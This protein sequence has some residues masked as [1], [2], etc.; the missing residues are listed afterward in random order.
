[1]A[2]AAP[3]ID[4]AAPDRAPTSWDVL[5]DRLGRVGVGAEASEAAAVEAADLGEEAIPSLVATWGLPDD[6]AAKAVSLLQAWKAGRPVSLVG[7]E[8]AE[9]VQGRT[10]ELLATGMDPDAAAWTALRESESGA[11]AI[12]P[13]LET[14][15]RFGGSR[16]LGR[17][18]GDA[19]WAL[20]FCRTCPSIDVMLGEPRAT[21][22]TVSG[23][24]ASGIDCKMYRFL[25]R[26]GRTY[27]F[28]TCD[29][30]GTATFDTILNGYYTQCGSAGSADDEC[31]VLSR[32]TVTSPAA[33]YVYVQ[34]RDKNQRGGSYTLSYADVTPAGGGA[35][36]TC[37]AFDFGTLTPTTTYQT[38]SSTVPAGGC[39][40]YRFQGLVNH[41]YRFTT[42]EGGG[43]ASFDAALD[44]LR[45]N[46]AAG[47]SNDDTCGLHPQV[48]VR[49]NASGYVYVRVRGGLTGGSYTLA[50]KDASN[51]CLPCPIYNFGP[52]TPT[53]AWTTHAGS[54]AAGQTCKRYGFYLTAGRTYRFSTCQGGGSASFDSTMKLLDGACATLASADDSCGT[55]SELTFTAATTALHYL[56]IG[57]KTTAGPYTLAYTEICRSCGDPEAILPIPNDGYQSYSDSLAPG[58]CAVYGVDLFAGGTYLF[59]FCG[60]PASASFDT[61]LELRPPGCGAGAANDNA[62]ALLSS[63][64]Y[65]ASVTGRH[66]LRVSAVSGSGPFSLAYRANCRGCDDPSSILPSPTPSYQLQQGYLIDGNCARYGVDL[67]SGRRYQFTFCP[68]TGGSA[69]FDTNLELKPPGCGAAV[70][71]NDNAC[72]AQARIDYTATATG[73]HVLRIGTSGGSGDYTLAY[74]ETCGDCAN[75]RA[76]LVPPTSTIYDQRSDTL[77]A[78][79]CV[80]YAAA[81]DAGHIYRFTFCGDAGG[82]SAFD[83]KIEILDSACAVLQTDATSTACPTQAESDFTAPSTGTYHVR[84]TSDSASGEGS[85]TLAYLEI[86]Q[87]CPASEYVLQPSFASQNVG[88]GV[89]RGGNTSYEMVTIPGRRYLYSFCP[90]D[91]GLATFD[92]RMTLRDAACAT[93]ATA[94]DT[95][96]TRSKIVHLATETTEHLTVDPKVDSPTMGYR[97]VYRDLAGCDVASANASFGPLSAGSAQA[98][99]ADTLAADEVKIYRFTV[100][101]P[102]TGRTMSF[103]LCPSGPGLSGGSA[104]FGSSLDV[105]NGNDGDC[106][107]MASDSDSCG[108]DA[109]IETLAVP[110]TVP[111]TFT[112]VVAIAGDSNSDSGSFTLAYQVQ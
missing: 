59:T 45:A 111:G 43:T 47:P 48:D 93:T 92:T 15:R 66:F 24:L 69:F 112:F 40:V 58:G 46:C 25:A 21:P 94:D 101:A 89:V 60:G 85:F 36:A 87:A 95:C 19:R 18:A 81:L 6:A 88:G 44:T 80:V 26:A 102:A 29:A 52:Y 53:Q 5:V 70:A 38:H 31:G 71:S 51:D 32:L 57:T 75:P 62:C 49:L 65:T 16:E 12:E 7:V 13:T 35:C 96:G 68:G 99:P 63:I 106:T 2:A 4:L 14:G 109:R 39:R 103:S 61:V 20:A 74:A 67:V 33:G 9:E 55:S 107:L 98:A 78:G 105:F 79:G 56:E 50:Y 90:E 42:C 76:T 54:I 1:M 83:S 73:R 82:A 77:I 86:G 17:E 11:L 34:I 22:Q 64:T 37:P 110:G 28:S 104:A 30:G 10:E 23:T 41:S 91:Q 100:A 108:D 84:V 72:G 3:L 27:R 97:L 8:T